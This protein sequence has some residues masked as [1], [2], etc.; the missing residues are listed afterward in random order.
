MILYKMAMVALKRS[1]EFLALEALLLSMVELFEQLGK[2]IVEYFSIFSA[3]RHFVRR[4]GTVW[5]IIRN[6]RVK[7]IG[8]LSSGSG[9]I[10]LL[11]TDLA[12]ILF[13]GADPFRE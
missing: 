7:L 10:V 13:G 4:S 6:I 8:I 5:L 1:P 11:S 3:S 12:A 9:D 2:S